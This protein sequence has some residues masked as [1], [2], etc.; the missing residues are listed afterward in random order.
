M[1]GMQDP[2]AG[3]DAKLQLARQI[4]ERCREQYGEDHEQTRFMQQYVATIEKPG[5]DE[6]SQAQ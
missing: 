5:T 4:Y 1:K 2:I 6:T 3:E